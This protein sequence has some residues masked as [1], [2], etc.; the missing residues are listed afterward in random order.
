VPHVIPPAVTRDDEFF[1]QGVAEGRLLL[2]R[3]AECSNLQ[4]PPSPMCPVCGSLE[5]TVQEAS[6]RGTVHSWIVSRHPTELDDVP[7]IVAL[8][9]LEEGVR[10]V[11]NLQDIDPAGVVNDMDV[12]LVFREVDGVKLAQFRPAGTEG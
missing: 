4:H 7:R 11:S 2:A 1:W 9:E 10:L 8:I 3:C 5:W 12:E 6:G